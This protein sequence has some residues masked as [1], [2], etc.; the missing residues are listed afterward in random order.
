MRFALAWVLSIFAFSSLSVAQ[1]LVPNG[2]FES[3]RDQPDGWTLVGGKG[4]W[5]KDGPPAGLRTVSITGGGKDNSSWRSGRIA[6]APQAVYRLRFQARSMGASG[7]T[8]ISGPGFCNRDL[9][10]ISP[11]WQ[12]HESIFVTP[13][14]L[15]DEECNL[16]FGQ[17]EVNGT[18]AFAAVQLHPAIPLYSREGEL[19]LG[20]GETLIGNEYTF[21]APYRGES[22]NQSRALCANDCDFN[23][24]RW[25]FAKGSEVI[26]RHRL[27]G[28]KQASAELNVSVVWHARGQLNVEASVNGKT[29]QILDS[30]DKLTG[31][32]FAIPATLMPA[33]EVWIRLS[34]SAADG[35]PSLQ[36]GYYSY[37]ATVSG[38]PAQLVGAT[39]FLAV[40]KSDPRLAVKVEGIGEAVPGGK[41]VVIAAVRNSGNASIDANITVDDQSQGPPAEFSRWAAPQTLKPGDNATERVYALEY[42]GTNRLLFA[43]KVGE[44]A[45]YSAETTVLVPALHD[46]SYGQPCSRRKTML[47]C[48]GPAAATGSAAPGRCH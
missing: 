10:S 8:P 9:G 37:R 39:R 27:A 44:D 20:E 3:G 31:K 38:P 25:C 6:F 24:D 46:S 16:R 33:D 15:R 42:P 1:S 48:G 4:E 26:Y 2:A 14:T 12:T 17:W 45:I 41:N 5:L 22:R 36:V 40:T 21:D 18:V 11:D 28:R 29:W 34:A 13:A 43:I 47:R 19:E 35:N 23:T 7:G 30:I 32:S